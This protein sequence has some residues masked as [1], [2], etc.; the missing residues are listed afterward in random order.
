M[1]P[2]MSKW[3]ETAKRAEGQHKDESDA[4]FVRVVEGA[5]AWVLEA[6]RKAHQGTL[7]SDWVFAECAAAAEAIDD[8]DDDALACEDGGD[9]ITDHAGERVDVYTKVLFQWATDF[10]LTE[11]F[12]DAEEHAEGMFD[13]H[14][15]TSKRLGVIQFCAIESIVRTM[16]EAFNEQ[17]EENAEYEHSSIEECVAAGTHLRSCDRDGYCNACG[18][19]GEESKS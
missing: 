14:A 18:E 1:K 8:C 4:T 13:P 2:E 3:F 10:C 9:W 5:P 11:I 19:Q 17:R 12:G 16:L 7:P 15:D 6:V